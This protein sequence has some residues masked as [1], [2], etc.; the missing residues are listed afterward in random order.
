MADD[1]LSAT[2]S[3]ERLSTF[4]PITSGSSSGKLQ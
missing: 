1:M 3:F 2:T 4:A